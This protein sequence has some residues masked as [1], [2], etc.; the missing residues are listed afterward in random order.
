M[1]DRD[2]PVREN[3]FQTDD[4]VWFAHGH[5]ASCWLFL[6]AAETRQDKQLQVGKR[7]VRLV[8]VWRRDGG[9]WMDQIPMPR[10]LPRSMP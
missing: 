6:T 9:R 5:A 1:V 8:I 7:G 10:P 4:T 3:S 2:S